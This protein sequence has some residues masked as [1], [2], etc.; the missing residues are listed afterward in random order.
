MQ[1]LGFVRSLQVTACGSA[2]YIAGD[3]AILSAHGARGFSGRFSVGDDG[4]MLLEIVDAGE[5]YPRASDVTLFYPG[6]E[7]AMSGTIVAL[8][9]NASWMAGAERVAE[10]GEW[11]LCA[12]AGNISARSVGG[13]GFRAEYTVV[14]GALAW[15]VVAHGSG[16]VG[17]EKVNVTL[18]D[19]ACRCGSAI[20]SLTVLDGGENY[21]AGQLVFAAAGGG[22]AANV[23]FAA[24]LDGSVITDSVTL[25]AGG[26]GGGYLTAPTMW[27]ANG[28]AILD[29]C[30]HTPSYNTS[31]HLRYECD[32]GLVVLLSVGAEAGSCLRALVAHGAEVTAVGDNSSILLLC[33]DE[34][35]LHDGGNVSGVPSSPWLERSPADTWNASVAPDITTVALPHSAASLFTIREVSNYTVVESSG[36][37]ALDALATGIL[38]GAVP[39]YEADQSVTFDVSFSF[40]DVSLLDSTPTLFPNGT[41]R[42]AAAPH[43]NGLAVFAATLSDDGGVARGGNETSWPFAPEFSEAV[44]FLYGDHPENDV[45]ALGATMCS[46]SAC[47]R[48]FGVRLHPLNN[49]PIFT[50]LHPGVVAHEDAGVVLQMAFAVGISAGK[51]NE[52]HQRLSFTVTTLDGAELLAAQPTLNVSGALLFATFLDAFGAGSYSVVLIDDHGTDNLGRNVSVEHLFNVTILPVNDVP[53]FSFTAA[54][55]SGTDLAEQSVLGSTGNMINEMIMLPVDPLALTDIFAS[56]VDVWEGSSH[57]IFDL[58]SGQTPGP[59]NEQEQSL[60][61]ILVQISGNPL[62]FV[63][64]QAPRISPDGT[65][66]LALKPAVY[67]TAVF[68]VTLADSGGTDRGGVDVSGIQQLTLDILFVNHPPTF[69][70]TPAMAVL[71]NSGGPQLVEEFFSEINLGD[72]EEGWQELTFV[73][74][75]SAGDADLFDTLPSFTPD[76][77]LNFSVATQKYGVG[78]YSVV[79]VDDGGTA[80]GGRN[81]STP[82][83]FSIAVLFVNQAPTFSLA[84]PNRSVLEDAGLFTQEGFAL[85][86]LAG[87]SGVPREDAQNISFVVE[88]TAGSPALFAAP[89][90]QIDALGTLR[91]TPANDEFGDATFRVTLWD[92]DGTERGGV[93]R[94]L[95]AV[96]SL[97]VQSVNDRPVFSLAEALTVCEAGADGELVELPLFATM[98]VPGPWNEAGQALS[99]D[100]GRCDGSSGLFWVVPTISRDGNLSFALAPRANGDVTCDFSLHDDGGVA[101]GGEDVSLQLSLAITVERVNGAPAFSL[102]KSVLHIYE[103]VP[104]LTPQTHDFTELVK[105]LSPGP[106]GAGDEDAQGVTFRM[107]GEG[108]LPSV[109]DAP[110]A[111]TMQGGL[112]VLHLSLAAGEFTVAPLMLEIEAEDD[113]SEAGRACSGLEENRTVHSVGVFVHMVNTAPVFDSKPLVTVLEDADPFLDAAFLLS[114][115]QG[116]TSRT[117]PAQAVTFT[118]RQ[119]TQRQDLFFTQPSISSTGA[120]AFQV[121]PSKYGTALFEVTARDNGGRAGGGEDTSVAHSLVVVVELVNHAPRFTL[122]GNVTVWQNT[123]NHSMAGFA[124]LLSNGDQ[125]EASQHVSYEV[126][127]ISG[128]ALLLAAPPAISLAGELSLQL[129][130]DAYGAA[131]F[132][133]VAVDDAGTAHGGANASAPLLLDV[134]VLFVNQAPSFALAGGNAT[135]NE[136]A[137]AV[138]IEA[139]ALDILAGPA[140]IPGEDAQAVVFVVTQESGSSALLARLPAVTANGTLLLEPSADENGVALFRVMAMDSGGVARE[141][142][143]ASE[144][145]FFSVVVLP[146]NDP[147]RFALLSPAVVSVCHD[148]GAVRHA[149]ALNIS[150]PENEA[151]QPLSFLLHQVA[152]AAGSL[153]SLFSEPPAVD[154]AGFLTLAPAGALG[155]ILLAIQAVDSGAQEARSPEQNFTLAVELHN[156]PPSFTLLPPYTIWQRRGSRTEFFSPG[157]PGGPGGGGGDDASRGKA[158]TLV[159]GGSQPQA[160]PFAA[161]IS[162]G[163][164]IE[165]GQSLT[166]RVE[167]VS[168]NASFLTA[169]P[170]VA[171][172]GTLTFDTHPEATQGFAEFAVTLQDD[173]GAA[174]CGRGAQRRTGADTSSPLRLLISVSPAYVT[175]LITFEGL[176]L[177]VSTLGD[178]QAA[179]AGALRVE[180]ALLYLEPAW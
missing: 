62:W 42:F 59:W 76:G 133:V 130:H 88:Q 60:S 175:F 98:I 102:V 100:V 25:P 95:D 29:T 126:T 75:F 21:T 2:N 151:G 135:I 30:A 36:E 125:E 1:P 90:P 120:L 58:M 19:P 82:R 78:N 14:G 164:G 101:D 55:F 45:V 168:G 8:A 27:V 124:T 119:T 43:L 161:N 40:G 31:R 105:S 67:G 38:P 91:F 49:A 70:A 136:D 178:V 80:R 113:G 173:G 108:A 13:G 33:G 86:I 54:N 171:L 104:A 154:V 134:F 51:P 84:F 145:R 172:D 65:L 85:S 66:S 116:S 50:L 9:A 103:H 6:T 150:S 93:N 123:G 127:L 158:F 53:L 180:Y 77:V 166:F 118:V 156:H 137:G 73:V 115:Q 37:Q 44:R 152:G 61:F 34:D 170:S 143:D 132:A 15:T 72:A 5:A 20:S 174:P 10:G 4:G 47:G 106:P 63:P 117:E 7:E 94:S 71:Q 167:L 179:I 79:A 12:P 121:A 23:S 155:S 18:S 160:E 142:S 129:Q 110:P 162:A 35:A 97:H 112:P 141:G 140:G 41:L 89:G 111:V 48:L 26:L 149:L 114:Y 17:G 99:F 131:R 165:G 176:I 22:G 74:T 11:A 3:L 177:D 147:T 32:Q 92:S 148:D 138:A 146:R 157:G 68:N 139:F 159:A 96:F 69:R 122:G 46:L 107:R 56:T 109:F 57:L 153:M 87:P 16:Y 81:I 163:P 39:G 83:N 24:L 52:A 128:N 64:G 28:S 169:P 144:P